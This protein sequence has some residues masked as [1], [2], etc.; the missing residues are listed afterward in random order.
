[1]GLLRAGRF[2]A[3]AL[4]VTVVRLRER[5]VVFLMYLG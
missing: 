3:G 4:V 2:F 1:L 5:V